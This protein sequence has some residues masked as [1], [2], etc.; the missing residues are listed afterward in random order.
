METPSEKD[1]STMIDY[2]RSLVPRRPLTYGQHIDY[3]QIQGYHVRAFA[4]CGALDLNLIWLFEQAV[5]PVEWAPSHVLNGRSGLTTDLPDN[6]LKIFLNQ[7]HPHLRQRYTLVH[8]WK[9]ALDYYDNDLLYRDLGSGDEEK[10]R[11]QREAIANEFAAELLMPMTLV[12]ERWWKTQD[13]QLLARD[14]NVSDEAMKT[15]LDKLG[16]LG[17]ARPRPRGYFR[18]RLILDQSAYAACAA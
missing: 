9:H 17:G 11:T 12:T 8:E 1:M 14:F 18:E 10:R 5:I 2:W 13:L 3:A 16:L 15:R 4:D 7:N 6:T